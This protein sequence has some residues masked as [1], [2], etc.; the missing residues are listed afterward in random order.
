MWCGKFYCAATNEH[1][2]L[3]KSQEEKDFDLTQVEGK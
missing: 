2:F 3:L 1:F